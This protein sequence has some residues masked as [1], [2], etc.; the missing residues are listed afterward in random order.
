MVILIQ[1][2]ECTSKSVPCLPRKIDWLFHHR[3]DELTK[4]MTDNAVNISFP[5]TISNTVIFTGA[6]ENLIERAIRSFK[7]LVLN[8]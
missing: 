6:Q 7:R 2:K 5:N 3:K 1:E 8:L 4:I